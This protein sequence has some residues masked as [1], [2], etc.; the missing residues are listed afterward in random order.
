MVGLTC[1]INAGSTFCGAQVHPRACGEQCDQ[2]LDFRFA[3]VRRFIPARAGNRPPQ[4]TQRSNTP[5]HPR[6]C[7]EQ[8]SVFS[9]TCPM[10]RFIPRA[11][12][13]QVARGQFQQQRNR[14]IPAR[15]GTVAH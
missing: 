10:H 3:L 13:E 11:C 15:A 7:G 9:T 14:F 2:D 5:V 6:A 12:G 1:A 8:L 4:G